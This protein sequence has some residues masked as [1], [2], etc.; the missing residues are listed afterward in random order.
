MR[1]GLDILGGVG[2]LVIVCIRPDYQGL[3]VGNLYIKSFVKE[4]RF[5]VKD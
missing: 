2:E 5:V 3:W 4:L 1:S